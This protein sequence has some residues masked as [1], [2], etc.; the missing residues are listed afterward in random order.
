MVAVQFKSSKT[1]KNSSAK[2]GWSKPAINNQRRTAAVA[3]ASNLLQGQQPACKLRA[4]SNCARHVAKE[5]TAQL[6]P[7]GDK[8]D[9]AASDAR[10][11]KELLH[12]VGV[13]GGEQRRKNANRGANDSGWTARTQ[14]ADTGIDGC[15]NTC[16]R[17]LIVL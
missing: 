12:N 4:D 6:F 3:A 7:N 16:S 9:T 2:E 1:S 13:K 10:N 11:Y 15:D 17:S 8:S 5:K 14:I